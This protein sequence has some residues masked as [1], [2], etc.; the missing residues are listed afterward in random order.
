MWTDV[1]TDRCDIANS[2]FLQFC[3]CAYK[4]YIAVIFLLFDFLKFGYGERKRQG[5][6]E[7]DVPISAAD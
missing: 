2:C 7:S 6:T 3:E 1:Q 4:C 5:V